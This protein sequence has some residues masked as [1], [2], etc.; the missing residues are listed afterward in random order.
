LSSSDQKI[1][2]LILLTIGVLIGIAVGL[3]IIARDMG[4][5]TMA[6][7][8]LNDPVYQIAV[9]ERIEPFGRLTL[10][11]EAIAVDAELAR[12]NE[13]EAAPAPL[14]GPQVYNDACKACHGGGIAGAPMT[15]D[16]AA[17][18][19]RIAQ[20]RDAVNQHALEDFTGAVGFMPPKGGRT[21][22]SDGEI[23]DAVQY[24]IDQAK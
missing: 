8:Q 1:F 22:L 6:R 15:G 24:L 12:V 4:N 19:P 3:F 23:I 10:D 14:T 5:E 7:M 17:W 9:N 20:G 2:D 13:A 21:D 18:G 11:G 16:A